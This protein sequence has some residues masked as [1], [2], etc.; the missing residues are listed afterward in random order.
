MGTVTYGIS[1]GLTHVWVQVQVR[2]S[3]YLAKAHA[4]TVASYPTHVVSDAVLSPASAVPGETGRCF[5][6]IESGAT[7]ALFSP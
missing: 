7:G 4:A 2:Y 5:G 1:A 6:G 3:D